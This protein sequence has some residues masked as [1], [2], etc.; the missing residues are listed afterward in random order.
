DA[1]ERPERTTVTVVRGRSVGPFP[2]VG[3]EVAEAP[4]LGIERMA[5][6]REI[7]R[8]ERADRARRL[9]RRVLEHRRE[10]ERARVVV[11]AVTVD[12]P[13]NVEH[14]VLEDTGVVRHEPE[15]REV[16]LGQIERSLREGLR[17]EN[18]TAS[19]AAPEA[20][21]IEALQVTAG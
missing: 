16:H 2:R 13:R 10:Q 19:M 4:P 15:V 3:H 6:E 9:D 12:A 8:R 18:D 11:E 21:S 20:C 1:A 7:A 17:A 5:D 14:R